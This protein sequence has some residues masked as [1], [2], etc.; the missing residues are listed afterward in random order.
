[1]EYRIECGKAIDR[2]TALEILAKSPYFHRPPQPFR[3]GEVWLS[4]VMPDYDV[5]LFPETYGFFLEV[6]SMT[7]ELSELLKRWFAELRKLGE[8]S[9]IDNDTEEEVKFW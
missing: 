6:S 4:S 5:R 8:C 7:D 1:M 2:A 3:E 9:I